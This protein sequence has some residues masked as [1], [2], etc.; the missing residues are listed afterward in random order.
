MNACD[1]G[2][3]KVMYEVNECPVCRALA[4]RDQKDEEV[5]EL[6]N[7]VDSLRSELDREFPF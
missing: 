5:Q 3:E 4:E 7:R 6:K 1:D 2:H